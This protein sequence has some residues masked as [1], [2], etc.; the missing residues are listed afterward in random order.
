MDLM[1]QIQ[2]MKDLAENA[3]KLEAKYL[4]MFELAGVDLY[5]PEDDDGKA[6]PLTVEELISNVLLNPPTEPEKW[7][8]ISSIPRYINDYLIVPEKEVVEQFNAATPAKA[9]TQTKR[10]VP[11][12]SYLD[13]SEDA[14]DNVD[15]VADPLPVGRNV[16]DLGEIEPEIARTDKTWAKAGHVPVGTTIVDEIGVLWFKAGKNQWIEVNNFDP[17]APDY[18]YDVDVTGG[19]PLYETVEPATIE[20][21]DE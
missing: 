4:K 2:Q 8:R 17:D 3:E 16:N 20:V 9:K 14:M 11:K 6:R 19:A 7:I 21:P 13:Q 18:W 5:T 10:N 1:Q 15:D 12:G